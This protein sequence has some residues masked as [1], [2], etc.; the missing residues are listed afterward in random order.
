M[1]VK[2][3]LRAVVAAAAARIRWAAA[4]D[5]WTTGYAYATLLVPSL[6]TA[7]MYFRWD[8]KCALFQV[9]L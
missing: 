9:V 7:P 8:F 1:Q 3:R 6:L 2:K 4:Y 5:L